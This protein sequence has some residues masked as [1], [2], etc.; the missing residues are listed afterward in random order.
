MVCGL[1]LAAPCIHAL[2]NSDTL[3]VT[4]IAA[5]GFGLFSGLFIAN[6]FPA[7]F[8]IISSAA[9]ATAVGMLNFFGALTSGFATLFGGMW[10]QTLGIDR[11]LSITAL[12]YLV[13]GAVLILGI[14]YLFPRDLAPGREP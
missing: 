11:L 9:R 7:T 14:T 10:K 8:D 6:I 4:R 1:V 3:L 12:A 13:A 5:T 2:G